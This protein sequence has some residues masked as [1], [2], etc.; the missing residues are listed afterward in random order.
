MQWGLLWAIS[1]SCAHFHEGFPLSFFCLKSGTWLPLVPPLGR[2]DWRPMDHVSWEGGPFDWDVAS[3]GHC[4]WFTSVLPLLGDCV[5]A[6][7]VRDG[8]WSRPHFWWVS[9]AL[10]EFSHL[11]QVGT[12]AS[13]AFQVWFVGGEEVVPLCFSV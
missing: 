1:T 8:R 12:S 6:S 11:T 5:C 10:F 9:F 13:R 4:S 3:M 2:S 7:P